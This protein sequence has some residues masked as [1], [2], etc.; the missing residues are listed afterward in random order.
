M[1]RPALAL[2]LSLNACAPSIGGT[3][4]LVAVDGKE[5]SV[6]TVY[7]GCDVTAT[8]TLQLDLEDG[9]SGAVSGAFTY[10]RAGTWDCGEGESG[11]TGHQLTGEVDGDHE[12][13]DEWE[14]DVDLDEGG[15]FDLVC[16]QEGDQLDCEDEARR[17][18]TLARR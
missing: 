12:G 8:V 15:S 2:C 13:D 5:P 18:Y 16:D 10:A 6:E 3:W 14:L 7:E 9:D 17:D 11:E 4:D 1:L